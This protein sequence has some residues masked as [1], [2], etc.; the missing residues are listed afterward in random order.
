MAIE[1]KKCGDTI[2]SRAQH[3]FHYCSCGGVAIDGGREYTRVIGNIKNIIEKQINI[4]VSQKK[5][6]DDWNLKLDKYGTI[7]KA[8]KKFIKK[9]SNKKALKKLKKEIKNLD[10]DLDTL[11]GV[12]R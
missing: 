6:Y 11:K 12:F 4:K 5:L 10:K 7:K 3:D 2:Y 9:A 8:L 1:C